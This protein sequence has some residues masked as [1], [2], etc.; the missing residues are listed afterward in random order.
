[1]HKPKR[2]ILFLIFAMLFTTLAFAKDL[3]LTI[4][5]DNNPYNEQLETRWGFSCLVE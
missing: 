3:D 1:M 4:V 5:Y 2:I